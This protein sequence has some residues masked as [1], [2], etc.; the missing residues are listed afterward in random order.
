MTLR[1]LVALAALGMATGALAQA[2]ITA[3]LAAEVHRIMPKVPGQFTLAEEEPVPPALPGISAGEVFA[4]PCEEMAA[5]T[6]LGYG[7]EL[8]R[9]TAGRCSSGFNAGTLAG[10]A[11]ASLQSVQRLAG[12]RAGGEV[13]EEKLPDGA[14]LVRF[15][16]VLVGHGLVVIHSAAIIEPESGAAVIVQAS[17]RPMCDNLRRFFDKAPLCT[18]P[19]AFLKDVATGL[20]RR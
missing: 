17:N 1:L 14:T 9:I 13:I 3:Q 19:S 18:D 11:R 8:G 12:P 15:P 2:R 4:A 6:M 5:L 20:R 7:N 16:L 10:R